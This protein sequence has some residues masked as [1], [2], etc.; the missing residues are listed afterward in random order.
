MFCPSSWRADL[1]DDDYDDDDDYGDDINDNDDNNDDHRGVSAL[2]W[3]PCGR[4][5][6]VAACQDNNNVSSSVVRS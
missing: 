6:A 2:A 1:G 5:L 3:S 4:R